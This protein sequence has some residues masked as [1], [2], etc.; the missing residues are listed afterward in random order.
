[1]ISAAPHVE[2]IHEPFNPRVISGMR[3]KP[4]KHWFQHI[5]DENSDEYAPM[6]D[7]IIHYRYPLRENIARIKS[8]RNVPSIIKEQALCLFQPESKRLGI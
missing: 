5:C 8:V 3:P 4:F 7:R 2:Y 6:L 1:M